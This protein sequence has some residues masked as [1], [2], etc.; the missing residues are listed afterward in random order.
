MPMVQAEETR[1]MKRQ[2]MG[3]TTRKIKSL[4]MRLVK[5]HPNLPKTTRD[6]GR[7]QLPLIHILAKAI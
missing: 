1:I 6:K 4:L 2:L 7:L 3:Q 5:D